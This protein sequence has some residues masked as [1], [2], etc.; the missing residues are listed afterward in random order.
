MPWRVPHQYNFAFET[1]PDPT[2]DVGVAGAQQFVLEKVPMWLVKYA[3]KGEK[4]AFFTTNDA[5][6]EPLLKQLLASRNGV[7]VEADLP[8]PL[9]GYPGALG[10]DLS[11][12]AGDFPAILRK[13]EQ[14][15]VAKG[16]AGRFGTW[17]FSYGFTTTAGL[18]EYANRV[19]QGT[20]KRNNLQDL[21]SAYG[22]YTPG[23]KWNGTLYAD[24][25]TGIRTRMALVYM[26]CYVFGGINGG[27]YLAT[28]SVK[29]P[30]KY[31]VIKKH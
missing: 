9:M 10:L 2:S 3:P 1:A 28:T 23:A 11:K 18:G 5:H 20:A 6:T 15:V 25:N 8:S 29:V 19:V 21:F 30:E 12:Q 24:A 14:G 31:Y 22:K 17:A 7:F 26:D 27:H 4:V 16:G 13:V